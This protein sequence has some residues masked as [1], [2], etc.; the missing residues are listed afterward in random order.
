VTTRLWL[1]AALWLAVL[2]VPAARG[3]D[4]KYLDRATGKEVILREAQVLD[5]SPAGITVE[6][7][8]KKPFKIS[9]LDIRDVNYNAEEIKPLKYLDYRKPLGSLDRALLPS[10]PEAAKP[11][12]YKEALAAFKELIPQVPEL[13]ALEKVRRHILFRQA[14]TV[15]RLAQI[16]PTRRE[17]A[18]T[19]LEAFIENEKH[20][21]GWQIGP[22]LVMVAGLQE[23]RGD[24]AAVQKTYEQLSK[25]EG[26][27]PEIRATSLL[28]VARTLLKTGKYAAAHTRLAQLKGLLPAN[29]PQAGKVEVY[30][31]QCEALGNDPAQGAQAEKRLRQLATTTSDPGTRALIHN[32]LGDYYLKK[33]RPEDAFWE[34]LRVDVMYNTDRYEHARALY[35]LT[36][37]FREVKKD[38]DRA[39]QCLSQ[40]K[41]KR[42]AGLEFQKKALEK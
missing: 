36:R 11:Q 13:R 42:F 19:M 2:A 38:G 15:Y 33:E 3:A 5:E 8:G 25:V 39:D 20:T 14:E 30:L 16:D 40:L 41:D 6:Q 27:S 34:F 31:A 37:L 10:T 17:E 12:L 24:F 1:K 35:H 7:R 32:T 9:A 28:N 26:I 21:K 18:R 4:V 29:N 23:S 22:A